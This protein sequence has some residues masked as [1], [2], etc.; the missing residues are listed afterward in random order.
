[1]FPYSFLCVLVAPGK[2]SLILYWYNILKVLI[3]QF[4][5]NLI[6]YLSEDEIYEVNFLASEIGS[7]YLLLQKRTSCPCVSTIC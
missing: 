1:M 3:N 2:Y 6:W 5:N 4:F 7:A